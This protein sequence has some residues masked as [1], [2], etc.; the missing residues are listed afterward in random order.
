MTA[1]HLNLIVICN[2]CIQLK[3]Q[4][5]LVNSKNKSTKIECDLRNNVHGYA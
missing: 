5:L 2:L 1:Q 3:S 4:D